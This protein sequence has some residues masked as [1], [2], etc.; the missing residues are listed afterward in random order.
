M[1]TGGGGMPGVAGV[2]G[3]VPGTTPIGATLI[4]GE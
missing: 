2:L 1:A 3:V 4:G